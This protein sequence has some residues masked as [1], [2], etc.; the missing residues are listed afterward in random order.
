MAGR[1][2][3]RLRSFAP[4][5]LRAHSLFLL[6]LCGSQ[7]DSLSAS[8][9][10]DAFYNNSAKRSRLNHV[11]SALEVYTCHYV[12]VGS[13]AAAPTNQ[14]KA[15]AAATAA[16][17]AANAA[18]AE[19]AVDIALIEAQIHHFLTHGE[20]LNDS[21][22]RALMARLREEEEAVKKRMAEA[23]ATAKSLAVA[24]ALEH[25]RAAAAAASAAAAAESDRL[26]DMADVSVAQSSAGSSVS[27]T[28]LISSSLMEDCPS[29]E[30][31]PQSAAQSQPPTPPSPALNGSSSSSNAVASSE[32]SNAVMAATPRNGVVA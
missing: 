27:S 6:A 18:H 17:N 4:P 12:P 1:V 2:L 20:I 25:Q 3:K 16:A 28:G 5:C 32:D 13:E 24:A 9:L 7:Y 26:R 31:A 19:G 30:S 21:K 29:D 10:F 23:D 11:P 14:T 8:T 15:D 22:G